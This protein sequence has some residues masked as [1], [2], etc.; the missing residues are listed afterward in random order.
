MRILKEIR[1][2]LGNYHVKSGIYHFYRGEYKQAIEF[3]SRAR[4]GSDG[5]GESDAGIARYYLTE[6]HLSAA[7]LAEADGDGDREIEELRAAAE[8]TP[9]VP[10]ILFRL[11]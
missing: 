9:G 3:F 7:E 5:Q 11:A 4:V 10:D 8:V 6:A 2:V 1:S